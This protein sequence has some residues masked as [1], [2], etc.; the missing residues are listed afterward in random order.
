M[1]PLIILQLHV[2]SVQQ[3]LDMMKQRWRWALDM[4]RQRW[5]RGVGAVCGRGECQAGAVVER[6]RRVWSRFPLCAL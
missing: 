4:M 2:V 5:G 6:Q 1:A 3:A